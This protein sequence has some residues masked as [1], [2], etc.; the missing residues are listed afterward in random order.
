MKL[1]LTSVTLRVFIFTFL[2]LS[3][4]KFFFLKTDF[5][6]VGTNLKLL[7]S[8]TSLV[9]QWLRIHLPMQMDLTWV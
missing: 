7:F 2:F 5:K 4:M 8:Q 1:L 9:V 6:H 3:L